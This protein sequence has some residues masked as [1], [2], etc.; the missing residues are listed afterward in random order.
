MPD[1]LFPVCQ[2]QEKRMPF[3]IMWMMLACIT[4][5]SAATT[6][7][8]GDPGCTL[9]P[10]GPTYNSGWTRYTASLNGPYSITPTQFYCS[11]SID[12]IFYTLPDPVE[13]ETF[14][15]V[16]HF[17]DSTHSS[18]QFSNSTIPYV[19]GSDYRISLFSSYAQNM[20]YTSGSYSWV[21][22]Q[23]FRRISNPDSIATS[24]IPIELFEG[25][26]VMLASEEVIVTA[27]EPSTLCFD[28]AILLALACNRGYAHFRRRNNFCA[29]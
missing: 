21:E 23:A 17:F 3:R 14:L 18:P 12:L 13:G 15:N 6:Q 16:R 26:P 10:Y 25:E 8:M 5:L 9:L 4:G 2:S 27:P 29:Q 1:G 19:L 20:M 24:D 28:G 11:A 22:V 7:L